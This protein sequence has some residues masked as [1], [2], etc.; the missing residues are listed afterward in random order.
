[1]IIIQKEIKTEMILSDTALLEI[2]TPVSY[3]KTHEKQVESAD[4]F[5]NCKLRQVTFMRH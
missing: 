5:G 1:M 3:R 2:K 4:F